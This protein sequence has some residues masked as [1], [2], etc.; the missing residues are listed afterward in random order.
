MCLF[1]CIQRLIKPNGSNSNGSN[2]NGSNSNDSNSNSSNSNDSNSN[3][4]NP[5]Y[6]VWA[7]DK[8]PP[9]Y[10]I[11]DNPP[12]YYTIY[13]QENPEY[14]IKIELIKKFQNSKTKEI[15]EIINN[16]RNNINYNYLILSDKSPSPAEIIRYL[17]KN[18]STNKDIMLYMINNDKNN[19][20]IK[21]GKNKH[22]LNN[23]SK[24]FL[25][26]T[27][28]LNININNVLYNFSKYKGSVFSTIFM[29]EAKWKSSATHSTYFFHNKNTLS[30]NNFIKLF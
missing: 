7:M 6:Q 23:N 8:E 13:Y 9:E 2:S 24:I 3:D 12:S 14:N 17:V 28:N 26:G 16:I 29:N 1:K 25:I 19:C 20:N 5:N 4:S 15:E 27:S 21:I 10:N 11:L 22:T 18:R 30:I